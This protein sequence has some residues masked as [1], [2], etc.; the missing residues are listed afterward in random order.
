M[1]SPTHHFDRG[2]RRARCTEWEGSIVRSLNTHWCE[3]SACCRCT[4]ASK[5]GYMGIDEGEKKRRNGTSCAR[6]CLLSATPPLAVQR[7]SPSRLFPFLPSPKVQYMKTWIWRDLQQV[8][9]HRLI[10]EGQVCFT[11]CFVRPFTFLFKGEPKLV[12]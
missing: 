1:T 11:Q 3:N 12:M 7:P 8:S 9:F 2:W 4:F 5:R 10:P 6:T